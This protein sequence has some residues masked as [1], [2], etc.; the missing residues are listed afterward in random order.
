MALYSERDQYTTIGAI[1]PMMAYDYEDMF[2]SVY[3]DG[4]EYT[5]P[6]NKIEFTMEREDD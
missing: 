6:D 5:L 3:F 2:S 1:G 4:L